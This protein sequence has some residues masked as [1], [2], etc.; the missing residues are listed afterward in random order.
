[1][2]NNVYLVITM[3]AAI[4]GSAIS[5][6]NFLNNKKEFQQKLTAD[7]SSKTRLKWIDDVREHTSNLAKA[8]RILKVKNNISNSQNDKEEA[9]ADFIQEINYLIL[10]F[11]INEATAQ[12]EEI[13]NFDI[14]KEW[15]PLVYYKD[16]LPEEEDR[17]QKS[18]VEIQKYRE[19]NEKILKPLFHYYSSNEDNS[20]KNKYMIMLLNNFEQNAADVGIYDPLEKS[21]YM[22][23]DAMR[24][25]VIDRYFNEILKA[26]NIYISEEDAKAKKGL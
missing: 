6:V 13:N 4:V 15:N 17:T 5:F 1:M 24:D 7:L 23:K 11:P 3:I 21:K 22:S 9:Y 20:L 26:I 16:P 10:F 25:R 8:Y 12:N 19:D 2:L 14:A 18:V